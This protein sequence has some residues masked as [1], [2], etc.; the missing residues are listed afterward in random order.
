M[1]KYFAIFR[2]RKE[3]EMPWECSSQPTE[4]EV[5]ILRAL[6]ENGPSPVRVIHEAV[7]QTKETNYSTTVKML[8]VML[9]KKLVA[10][11]ESVRPHVYRT[12]KTRSTTQKGM[13]RDLMDRVYDGS[14]G[15]MVI[16]ALSSKKATPE[17]LKEV[18]ELLDRLQQD[19]QS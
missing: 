12:A 16:Q 4:T 9:E 15:R 19:E 14:P 10:R 6:W 13:L 8:S 7:S 11:D 3:P 1:A 2:A 17:E 18:R 5:R